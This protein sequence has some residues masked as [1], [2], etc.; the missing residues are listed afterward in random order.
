MKKF[1]SII[2]TLLVMT[3]LV[4]ST[5]NTTTP[6]KRS[7]MGSTLLGNK[8]YVAGGINFWGSS[9]S[10]EAYDIAKGKWEKLPS[11]PKELNHV[12]LAA[13]DGKIYLSGGFFNMRQTNFSDVLYAY[14]IAAKQWNMVTKMP[15][16]RA[17]HI[18]IQRGGYLHLIGGRN[19]T[20]IE[21]FHLNTQKWET[22]KI[23]ALP[24]KRD[25]ISVLQSEQKLYIVGGRHKGVVKEDCWEYDFDTHKWR[26]FAAL[27][28]PRGGQSACLHNQQIHIIGGEDL[29]AG[30]TFGRHDIYDLPKKEWQTGKGL[31]TTRHGFIAE[32]FQNKWYVYGGG[33]KAGIKTLISATS[34]LELLDLQ[35]S[36]PETRRDASN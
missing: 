35:T 34:D 8:I 4:F 16:K 7:E 2:L 1:I 28:T 15:N 6:T 10:F 18:M 11:L 36:I 21:S 31:K 14:D 17:A 5:Q 24:E 26:T 30:K 13:Y 27:P 22:E 3:T 20:S 29:V 9:D 19:H 25:H 23:A 33:K 12:G 32:L